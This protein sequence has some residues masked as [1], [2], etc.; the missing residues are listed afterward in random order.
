MYIL[1]TNGKVIKKSEGGN[2]EEAAVS[3]SIGALSDA[4]DN[5]FFV[6]LER[7]NFGE[8]ASE[9]L[10]QSFSPEHDIYEKDEKEVKEVNKSIKI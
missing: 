8:N 6:S 10:T 4:N 2:L 9:R 7:K 1:T 5:N 3:G